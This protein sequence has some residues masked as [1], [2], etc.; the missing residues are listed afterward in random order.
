[1][2]YL[3]D[4]GDEIQLTASEGAAFTLH[5]D[6]IIRWHAETDHLPLGHQ[7]HLRLRFLATQD[8]FPLAQQLPMTPVDMGIPGRNPLLAT[9][10]RA[11]AVSTGQDLPMGTVDPYWYYL[12]GVVD[13]TAGRALNEQGSPAIVDTS[14]NYSDRELWPWAMR[15]LRPGNNVNGGWLHPERAAWNAS[16]LGGNTMRT[17]VTL[18]ASKHGN[19]APLTG[20]VWSDDR[21]LNIYVNGTA[22]SSFNVNQTDKPRK[23]GYTFN[24][25]QA[26]G[27]APG[28]NV[29]DFVWL[30]KN[31]PQADGA[32]SLF[33]QWYVIRVDLNM[34]FFERCT[35][36]NACLGY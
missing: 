30:L 17:F 16:P 23:V 10:T 36:G 18:P 2:S 32:A 31:N 12:K 26:D 13:Y 27:L 34:P 24:I 8:E 9:G 6:G 4:N 3:S 1:M 28:L 15:S 35:T 20:A 19:I 5:R 14:Y 29:L 33:A 21:M 11:P 22:L 7:Y 25:H